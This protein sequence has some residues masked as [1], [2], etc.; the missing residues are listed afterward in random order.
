MTPL[1]TWI[2]A[3]GAAVL[4]LASAT[5]ALAADPF[6]SK[7]IRV[8]VPTAA[9]GL[10]DV[11]TR[12]VARKMSE[13]LGQQ[14]I[15]DNRPGGDTLI[16]TRLVK[17]APADGY[18]L[19]FQASGISIFPH[20]KENPG[21]ELA[22][23]D[24]TPLGPFS[25]AP[26]MLMVGGGQPDKTLADFVTR[27]KANPGKFSFAHGGIGTPPHIGAV[28]FLQRAG[29][30]MQDIA[31]KGNAAAVPDVVGGRAEMIF[32]AYGTASGMIK[33]GRLRSLGVSSS[34]RLAS[35]PD[36]PTLAE[37]GFPGFSYYFWSGLL[38]PAG[39]PKE[40]L[41]K[42]SDALRY[43]VTSEEITQRFRNDGNEA[44]WLSPAQFSEYLGKEHAEM[45]RLARELKL[46]KQ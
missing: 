12:L 14:L 8:V 25:R 9:G 40:V 33:E 32:D 21:Y 26:L 5:G 36:I 46:P 42:L 19:L 34:S 20:I 35:A 45:G 30:Q 6:P 31:Y 39:V 15:I 43:A 10:G 3:I 22:T 1:K 23:K 7:P 2:H 16:G 11:Y 24:F 13:R 37:Q 18:T 44:F 17:E 28:M 29:L 41:D 38:A 27:I 4:T